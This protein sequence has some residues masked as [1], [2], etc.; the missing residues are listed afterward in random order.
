[1]NI[2]WPAIIDGGI[3]ILAG[4]YGTALAYGIAVGPRREAGPVAKLLPHFKWMGPA[5]IL[6]GFLLGW[7]SYSRA[8]HPP[9]QQLAQQ[10]S[11]KLSP[12]VQI[13]EVTRLDAIEGQADVISL[14]YTILAPLKA[15]DSLMQIR[16]KLHETGHAAACTNMDFERF[17]NNGY[18]IELRYSFLESSETVSILVTP[19]SCAYRG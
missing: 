15:A 14:H 6:F 1:M 13:D 7:Q 17:L 8:A 2:Y 12:P 3:P 11:S 9:A 16:S 18:S 5:L 10:I 4:M 19:G